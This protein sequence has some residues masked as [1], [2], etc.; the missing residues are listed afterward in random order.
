MKIAE[1]LATRYVH[2][3]VNTQLKKEQLVKAEWDIIP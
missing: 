3:D 2:P 1:I